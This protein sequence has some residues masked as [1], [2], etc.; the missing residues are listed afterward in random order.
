MDGP[1]GWKKEPERR[2]TGRKIHVVHFVRLDLDVE[3]TGVDRTVVE[4]HAANP[5]PPNVQINIEA[6]LGLPNRQSQQAPSPRPG[7]GALRWF[8]ALSPKPQERNC[9]EEAERRHLPCHLEK[10]PPGRES[11]SD[12]PAELGER[13]F[14]A[15]THEGIAMPECR[16]ARNW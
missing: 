10:Q 12:G 2:D 3:R 14:L 1:A 13:N 15:E 7:F 8:G 5:D 9:Q 11:G 6:E 4:F 16:P